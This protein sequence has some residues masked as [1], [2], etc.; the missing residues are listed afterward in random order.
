MIMGDDFD[1]NDKALYL[2]DGKVISGLNDV[3]PNTIQSVRV[4]KNP[5]KDNVYYILYGA[6]ALNGVVIIESK[7]PLFKPSAA[8]H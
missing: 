5:T 4:V 3:D 2:L 8:A 6:K 1:Y 7:K